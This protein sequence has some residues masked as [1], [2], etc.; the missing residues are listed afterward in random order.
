MKNRKDKLKFDY[1]FSLLLVKTICISVLFLLFNCTSN[2]VEESYGTVGEK[3]INGFDLLIERLESKYEV[4]QSSYIDIKKWNN[5]SLIL[6]LQ[7][8][9]YY[10][11]LPKD[12]DKDII[13]I[14]K[15]G[16]ESLGKNEPMVPVM[17]FQRGSTASAGFWQFQLQSLAKNKTEARNYI[18]AQIQN[19]NQIQELPSHFGLRKWFDQDVIVYNYYK[20][21]HRLMQRLPKTLPIRSVLGSTISPIPKFSIYTS[22]GIFFNEILTETKT[23]IYLISD[24]APFLNFYMARSEN[25]RLLDYVIEAA[26]HQRSGFDELLKKKPKILILDQFQTKEK[27]IE[28][29]HSM[30]AVFFKRPYN[31]LGALLI[32]LFGMFVWSRIKRDQLITVF[33][34]EDTDSDLIHHFQGVAERL[35]AVKQNSS[36]SIRKKLSHILKIKI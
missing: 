16:E 19:A 6:Y 7:K 24:T 15:A 36:I 34:L 20:Y 8:N 13:E 14:V 12:L 23:P 3:S 2:L 29:E 32:I 35:K 31:L 1:S 17:I 30:F 18:E 25:V 27:K 9:P 28:E 5:Y 22:Q 4:E 11:K 10:M 21:D 33:E 26:M